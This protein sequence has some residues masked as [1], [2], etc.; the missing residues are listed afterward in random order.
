MNNHVF[1]FIALLGASSASRVSMN[2]GVWT[3][4]DL[5]I[6]GKALDAILATPHLS[7][8]QL[9]SAQSVAAKVRAN[10]KAVETGNLKGAARSAKVGEALAALTGLEAEWAERTNKAKAKEEAADAH[11]A[12]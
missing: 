9:S 3:P 2:A 11:M 6:V 5:E 12:A 4:N 8:E 1:A 7:K 10:L